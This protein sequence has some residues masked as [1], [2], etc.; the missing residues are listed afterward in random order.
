MRKF[1]YSAW[2]FTIVVVIALATIIDYS[3]YTQ[4]AF[5]SSVVTMLYFMYH[6]F[7]REVE[8]VVYRVY[9]ERLKKEIRDE[10]REEVDRLYEDK[11]KKDIQ[12]MLRKPK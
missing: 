7:V 9:E 11:I 5:V 8:D 2:A 10:V 1:R 6:L 3:F 12:D 4:L